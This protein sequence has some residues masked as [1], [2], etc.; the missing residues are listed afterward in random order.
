[1]ALT[2]KQKRIFDFIR[3]YN[4]THGFSPTQEEIKDAFGLKSLGSVQRYLKYL[5]NAGLVELESRSHRGI[6]IPQCSATNVEPIPELPVLGKV[7]A[8]N[9]I[10]AIEQHDTTLQVPPHLLSKH[11]DQHFILEVEGESMIELGINP[12]D[13]LICLH[14]NTA[15]NGD[16]VIAYW[17]DEVTVKSFYHHSDGRIELRPANSSMDSFWPTSDSLRI[18]GRVVS[19][20]RQF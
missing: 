7:A 12:G 11:D 1:M 5:V 14:Q 4:N 8:G 2:K 3:D 19:L 15:K 16:I 10:E 6:I 13:Q 20:M 18:L 17:D 9:P